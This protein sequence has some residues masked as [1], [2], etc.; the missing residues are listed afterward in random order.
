MRPVDLKGKHFGLLVV[1]E[2]VSRKEGL[3]WR[4]KC[5]CENVVVVYAASL[6]SGRTRS[7]GC[8]KR[9]C[10]TKHG[11][12]GTRLYEIWENMNAR[13]SRSNH[14]LFKYYGGRGVTVCSEWK[15]S[16]V[17]F[18]DWALTSGYNDSLTIERVNNEGNYEAGNCRWATRYEQAQNRRK[19]AGRSALDAIDD[20]AL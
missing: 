19:P 16:F 18:R 3:F 8:L 17:A 7:C 13:C 5:R 6:K 2:R 20:P 1:L 9:D 15:N 14:T 4:C 10:H 11:G 12:C